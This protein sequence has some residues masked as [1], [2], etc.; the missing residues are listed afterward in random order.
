MKTVI[1]LIA[2]ALTVTSA[3]AWGDREQGALV[4]IVGTLLFQHVHRE[5]QR[6]Q[7]AQPQ[8]I[9]RDTPLRGFPPAPVVIV[10]ENA[11]IICPQGT[12]AF[13]MLRYDRYGRTYYE[14]DGCR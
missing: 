3:Q 9:I 7:P 8:V 11:Q 2:T 5:H 14:F 10:Q 12:A 4:G 1:A 6:P 13:Y